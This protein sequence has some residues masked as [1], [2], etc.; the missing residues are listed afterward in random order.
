MSRSGPPPAAQHRT[1]PLPSHDPQLP[2]SALRHLLEVCL[3][4]AAR[5]GETRGALESLNRWLTAELGRLPRAPGR[6]HG[7]LTP[8]ARGREG[9]EPSA[10]AEGS[11]TEALQMVLKRTRWKAAAC[12]VS[13]DR[14][15]L[16]HLEGGERTAAEAQL[17]N[18]ERVLRASLPELR[19]T[20][21]WMLDQPF[22]LRSNQ[23]GAFDVA[24]ETAA[25]LGLVADCYE[26]L[27]IAVEKA[28]ELDEAGAFRH[29]PPPAFLYLLA[30]AQSALLASIAEAPVRSDSDQ[31]DVFLWLKEQ[32]TRF[33]IY[34]DRHMRLDDL[35]DCTR[36]ADLQER[37]GRLAEELSKERKARR[38]RGQLLNKIR[39][40]VRKL[41]DD[42]SPAREDADAL[43][44]AL[45]RWGAAGLD[46]ADRALVD[47]LD[48]LK[49]RLESMDAEVAEAVRGLLG[50]SE[51]PPP[52]E[53]RHPESLSEAKPLLASLRVV[54]LAPA[55]HEVVAEALGAEL[56]AES[57]EVADVDLD[58]PKADRDLVLDGLL[59]GDDARL[60]LLG[61]RL[62]AEEY[63]GFKERCLAKKFAFVRLPGRLS[64]D[65]IAHQV[66][67]QV[68]WRL[69]AQLDGA[70]S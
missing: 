46:R 66:M 10:V 20:T 23:D 40:H 6:D 53:P 31:R 3:K 34:V 9:A 12:K 69:R 7:V 18:R 59:E 38:Q 50:G 49:A 47:L 37:V 64:A 43:H 13:V 11:L 39:F 1:P 27:S 19:D 22:G 44:V 36:S 57:L 70:T 30:E 48:G 61:V 45:Q 52:A 33:R 35:A 14:Q 28:R 15:G 21:P 58:G 25:K 5:S 4:E 41:L 32:T 26:T 24:D 8:P 29:G 60:F 16:R 55:G 51:Q 63:N 42:T 54:L 2:Q 65:A 62:E 56:G 67:R 17:A 68:G